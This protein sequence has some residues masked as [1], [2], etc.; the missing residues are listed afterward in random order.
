MRQLVDGAAIPTVNVGGIHSKPGRTQKMRYVF[1]TPDEEQQLRE[2]AARGPVVTA[3]D[4]PGARAIPLERSARGRRVV[5]VELIDLIPLA[6]L[7]GL[8]GLDVVSFPQAMISRPLVAATLGGR[9][10]R[11]LGDWPARRRDARADRA[12]D[13]A[14]RGVALSGVGI[15]L[16]GRRSD[17]RDPSGPFAGRNDVE[18]SRR[19]CHDVD[20]RMDDGEAAAAERACGPG[21]A[22][23]ALE[24][25]SRGAVIGLQIRGMTADFVRGAALT[26]I[27][28]SALAPLT[29][30]CTAIWSTDARL[31]RAFVAGLAASV[32]GGAA[33]KIFHSTSGALWLFAGGL[34]IGIFLVFF[35]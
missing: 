30:M 24:A 10:D 34:G 5:I 12:R 26:A 17:F 19:A 11:S 32:A 7:G 6:L 16:G 33:W 31:S 3:Q 2:L 8:L 28:Y 15:G 23:G 22:G 29:A 13:A 18:R 27:A 9:A 35:R 14:V 4:V 20:R 1:L 21:G 25:G